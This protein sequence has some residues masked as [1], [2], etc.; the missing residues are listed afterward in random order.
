[1][2]TATKIIEL[3]LGKLEIYCSVARRVAVDNN[4]ACKYT[5]IADKLPDLRLHA[6]ELSTG[7]Q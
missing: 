7:S 2:R 3:L 1:M 4:Y 6:N 5:A